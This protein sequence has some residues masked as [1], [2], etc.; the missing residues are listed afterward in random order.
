MS[1][2]SYTRTKSQLTPTSNFTATIF[3]IQLGPNGHQFHAHESVLN[4]SPKFRDEVHKAK[5]SKRATKQNLIQL[6]AHDPVA[7]E[8]MLQYLYKDTFQ[9][10]KTKPSA[11]D[12]MAEIRELMSLA[13]V[14]ISKA[15]TSTYALQ[16]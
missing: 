4:R 3:I 11:F 7:F 8:Q 16:R 10:S 14:R 5:S 13:K 12:R 15:I 9:L 2:Y 6:M 1:D